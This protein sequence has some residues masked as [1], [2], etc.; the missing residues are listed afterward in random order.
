MK[1]RFH[2]GVCGGLLFL[3]FGCAGE[4]PGPVDAARIRLDTDASPGPQTPDG[5]PVILA[6]GDS[7]TAGHMVDAPLAY[8]AQ[9]QDTLDREGYGYQVINQ[10]IGGDT[11]SGGM[12]R[13][14]AALALDPE[15]VILEL[16]GNDGLRGVPIQAAKA[17]LARMI[18]AFKE[19]GA[20]VVLAG[21]T[22]P[23]NY[24]PDYIR[25]FESMY[26]DLAET[27][28]IDR[29]PFFLEGLIDLDG[30]MDDY[31]RYM[32]ADGVHPTG[33]GYTIVARNVF[34]AIEPYLSR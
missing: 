6:F 12:A 21:L 1:A 26:V 18:E 4:T 33:E 28:Q 25:D 19:G 15:I 9:L 17:N 16:G 11:T 32:Q 13:L 29:I 10:G 5:R 24:G 34:D 27:H 3:G 2:I 31:R 14:D 8:P 23:R 20:R 30:P 22:L 7:L